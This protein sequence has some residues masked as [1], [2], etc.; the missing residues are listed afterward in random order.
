MIYHTKVKNRINVNS[1]P[2]YYIFLL[3]KGDQTAG[4]DSI[5][6]YSKKLEA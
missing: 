3:L 4:H 6:P 1:K 5:H 2:K